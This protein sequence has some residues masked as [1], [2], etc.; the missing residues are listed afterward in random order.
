MSQSL[1]R[2]AIHL[3][4]STK[5]REPFLFPAVWGETFAYLAGVFAAVGC[6]AIRVGGVADH[7]HALFLLART[8][9]LCKVVEEVKK[10]SSKWA[11][12]FVHPDFYWQGGYGAFAV[13]R[14]NEDRVAAYISDQERHHAGRSYQDE[15]RALLRAH[16][17]EWDEQHVWD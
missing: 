14:S 16:E 5:N 10:E 8:T 11:K 15:F 6:P 3:V 1:A 9:P 4:F 7:V 2:A 17:V 12:E 13:S